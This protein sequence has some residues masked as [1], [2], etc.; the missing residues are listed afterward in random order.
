MPSGRPSKFTQSL[1]NTICDRIASGK[2]LRSICADKKMPHLATVL[3]WVG[4]DDAF[5]EQYA[6]ARD[7]QADVL[8]DEMHHIA[9]TQVIGVKTVKK[10]TGTE[11]TEADMIDHRRLQIETRKWMLGKMAPKKYGD[12]SQVEMTGKDGGALEFKDVTDETRAKALAAFLAKTKAAS[13]E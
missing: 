9:D 1:A 4:K 11:T 10:P 12:K 8:F 2:S 6:R 3:R 5:R 7:V 13:G